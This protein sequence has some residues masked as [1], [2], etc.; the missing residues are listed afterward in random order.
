MESLLFLD[1]DSAVDALSEAVPG[2]R[3]AVEDAAVTTDIQ[4]EG[5]VPARAAQAYPDFLRLN[6]TRELE[7]CDRADHV[8]FDFTERNSIVI[9]LDAEGR[10][11]CRV[12]MAC[13]QS[14][15][16]APAQSLA[17]RA[18][19]ARGGR[20]AWR[21]EPLDLPFDVPPAVGMINLALTW[22]R[23]GGE[24][25]LFLVRPRSSSAGGDDAQAHWC[26]PLPMLEPVVEP[27]SSD[28]PEEDLAGYRMRGDVS[29]GSIDSSSK[30]GLD[31]PD[32]PP[33]L[34]LDDDEP[35]S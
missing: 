27:V 25:A 18:E 28:Y 30:T 9:V 24:L 29:D 1:R 3:Q 26:A 7:S 17:R 33:D 14:G 34:R 8:K 13:D 31:D 16:P 15:N 32:F 23:K 21:A 10:V 20:L 4:L 2:L 22:R 12:L 35:W 11:R 19:Y 5:Y 6:L